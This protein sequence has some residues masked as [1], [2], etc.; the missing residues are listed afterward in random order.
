[1]TEGARS[2]RSTIVADAGF[3]P[4]T[5]QMGLAVS[6]VLTTYFTPYWS[7]RVGARLVNVPRVGREF[8]RRSIP[9]E[10]SL[11]AQSFETVAELTR[12]AL[13]RVGMH[14]LDRRLLWHRN[15]NFDRRVA[16]TI[17]PATTLVSQYGASLASFARAKQFGGTTILDYPIARLDFAY[18]LLAE[19]ARLRPEFAET[20]LGSQALA[21]RAQDLR[22][23]ADEVDYADMV[24]VGS[25]FAAESFAGIVNPDRLAIVPYGV[26]TTAFRP[27]ADQHE[28]RP[29]RV[30][31]AGQLTQ[32][33]GIA[34]LLDAMQLLD[35]AAFELTVVGPIVG[36]GR[37]L[38]RYESRF[39]H[40]DGLAP[41]EM[42]SIYQKADVLALPSLVE[43]SAVV[44]LEAMAS[45]L[46]VIVTPNVGA[47]AVTD[48]VEGFIVPIRSSQAI[49]ASLEL[50]GSDEGLRREMSRAALSRSATLDWSTF[51]EKIRE[52]VLLSG[53]KAAAEERSAGA[54][55]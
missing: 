31:F 29:L 33:K 8:A 18:E 37:G 49:A 35:P 6:D 39:R 10:L 9:A 15:V 20:I 26:D 42:W 30:L 19:E 25:H 38:R 36:S 24:V 41:Q 5:R 22:R 32:R 14:R 27:K 16:A 52:L 53:A 40:L 54:V 47:D 1:V 11:R 28:A 13:G 21:P 3:L 7:G 46:P 2:R 55:G 43:G 4:T 51:R 17:E 48:G 50:L 34:Y 12:V 23:V 45:G 44:V